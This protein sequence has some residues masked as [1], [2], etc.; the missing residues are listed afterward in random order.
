MKNS[1]FSELLEAPKKTDS[2]EIIMSQD[3]FVDE[4]PEKTQK[5]EKSYEQY[6]ILRRDNRIRNAMVEKKF[7]KLRE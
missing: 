5:V 1:I 3:S 4:V 7:E 2:Q 6:R